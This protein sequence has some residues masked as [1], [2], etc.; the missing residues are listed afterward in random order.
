M[1]SDIFFSG[2]YFPNAVRNNLTVFCTV[3]RVALFTKQQINERSAQRSN[4][5]E[6]VSLLLIKKTELCIVKVQI[7][8]AN[9]I[10]NLFRGNKCDS[11][12][13]YDE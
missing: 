6:V 7:I 13:M 10:M 8:Y 5:H 12:M 11:P 2:C 4:K 1:T 9:V 3:P